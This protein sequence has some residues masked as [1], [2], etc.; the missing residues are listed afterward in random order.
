[1]ATE[2]EYARMFAAVAGPIM[3]RG[4]KSKADIRRLVAEAGRAVRAERN[5]ATHEISLRWKDEFARIKE[6][7]DAWQKAL[8]A[9]FRGEMQMIS[10]AIGDMEEGLQR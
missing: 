9:A 4:F 7:N 3:S 10:E 8:D 6:E 1:M 2:A 5:R